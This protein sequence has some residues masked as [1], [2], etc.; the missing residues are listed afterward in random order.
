MRRT[1]LILALAAGT[2]LAGC[3]RKG[4]QS[5]AV[6][7]L[8]SDPGAARAIR[9][10][11]V[12]G[13]VAVDAEARIVPALADRWIVTDDGQSYIFRLRDGTWPDGSPLTGETA[14]AALRQ[15]LAALRAS[16][17]EAE[18]ESIDEVRAMAGRV[19]EIRLSRPVPDLLQLLARPELGLAR[20]GAGTGPMALRRS[21]KQAVLT[22]IP[23]ERRGLPAVK[24]WNE[25]V[26]PVVISSTSARS[27]VAFFTAG[28][29]DVVL[30]GTFNEWPAVF[31]ASLPGPAIQVDRAVG[32]FGL[33]LA[34]TDGFL[35]EPEHREA[36][37]MAI[38]RRALAEALREPSWIATT[39]IVTPGTEGDAA[40]VA[41]RWGEL[42]IEQRRA[43]ATS[44]VARWRAR[45]GPVVLRIAMPT[46]SGADLVFARLA[47]DLGAAGFVTE[48]VTA[49]AAA[50]LRLIDEV[51]AYNRPGWFFYRL[52]CRARPS[53]CSS[54]ADAQFAAAQAIPDPAARPAAMAQAEA[55]LAADNVFIP[56]GAP[57]RWTLAGPDV[58]GLSANTLALHPLLPLAMR[59]TK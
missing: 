49:S 9:A 45:R 32:L 36:V 13:L 20:R 35:A 57:L 6:V 29:V 16:P 53:A 23:P 34:H 7:M 25:L 19:V 40:L 39:R 18:L 41:E 52:S 43:I 26:R 21:G 10:A 58:T 8:P 51:A 44:R 54:A 27:A 12:E 11:T 30:G 4:D 5:V 22:P 14:R 42:S 17:L 59:P 48:R 31:G 47:A 15:A 55:Q 38:D 56:F 1:L 3:G 2:A 50:D 33:A 46:G 37:A 24:D 28:R